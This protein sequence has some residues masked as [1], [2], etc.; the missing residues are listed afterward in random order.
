[1]LKLQNL[2]Y[3]IEENGEVI[4]IIKGVDLQ[5]EDGK[6]YVI[7]GPNG[8]GKSTLVKLIMGVLE[9]SEGQIS[10]D[11]QEIT[12]LAVDQ[13]ARLGLSFAF[14]KPVTFKGLKV[15]DLLDIAS[16]KK[17]NVGELCEIGRASCRE[18]V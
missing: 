18:R 15:K 17:N 12:N 16:G 7:T 9:A 8:S 2:K 4:Q 6:I 1:M 5:F 14:Q 3:Q 11:E 13:R 10:L